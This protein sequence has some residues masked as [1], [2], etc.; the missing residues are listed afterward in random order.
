MG[1]ACRRPAAGDADADADDARTR[2]AR[3]ATRRRDGARRRIDAALD[4]S[5]E[6][7]SRRDEATSER[8]DAAARERARS[9]GAKETRARRE[10]AGEE[11]GWWKARAPMPWTGPPAPAT[12]CELDVE[13]FYAEDVDSK[14]EHKGMPLYAWEGDAWTAPRMLEIVE[15]GLTCSNVDETLGRPCTLKMTNEEQ[16]EHLRNAIADLLRTV[17]FEFAM[18]AFEGADTPPDVACYRFLRR[19][20][21][22]CNGGVYCKLRQ[23]HKTKA[24]CLA[25]VMDSKNL[26]AALYARIF[27]LRCVKRFPPQTGFMHPALDAPATRERVVR[28]L[29]DTFDMFKVWPASEHHPAM[30]LGL[31][32]SAGVKK[33]LELDVRDAWFGVN[34][35]YEYVLSDPSEN[36][37]GKLPP[38]II[39]VKNVS[40]TLFSKSFIVHLAKQFAI[41]EFH[42]EPFANFIL[43]NTPYLLAAL[44]S[45]GK[46]F[47]SESA[48]N[49]FVICTGD[50][51]AEIHRRYGVEK[52]NQPMECGGERR[53]LLV[54][55]SIWLQS[56]SHTG[57][58]KVV[59]E[60]LNL[61]NREAQLPPNVVKPTAHTAHKRSLSL[62]G[63][64]NFTPKLPFT[65]GIRATVPSLTQ[66]MS[67][68]VRGI[69]LVLVLA[70]LALI[71][72]SPVRR[73]YAIVSGQSF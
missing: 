57:A 21:E 17:P 9:A 38:F 67:F 72:R 64:H 69:E 68:I 41:A 44:W 35:M 30:L 25:H 13:G 12:S 39:D 40:V 52:K 19:L 36:L 53:G 70:L 34:Q 50:A 4:G 2:G 3:R 48:R 20:C 26:G 66:C 65:T 28:E 43:T 62:T 56:I 58:A 61:R 6:T 73:V 45:V 1:N 27:M 22:A 42:P 55:S 60:E 24:A 49:K 47:L 32:S 63:V 59:V 33:F 16:I 23:L 5:S 8:G 51:S 31:V 15:H 46:L 54:G 37:S 29:S 10:R 7:M 18:R 14:R 11:G 71:L